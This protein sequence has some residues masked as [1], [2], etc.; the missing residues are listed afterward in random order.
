MLCTVS[1]HI[2]HSIILA[3]NV[4]VSHPDIAIC[5]LL[6]SHQAI[7]DIAYRKGSFTPD[8]RGNARRSTAAQHV[9]VWT[10]PAN[11]TCYYYWAT[12]PVWTNFKESSDRLP[13][14]SRLIVDRVI[15]TVKVAFWW[16]H[17]GVF[18]ASGRP[19]TSLNEVS[20]AFRSR[21]LIRRKFQVTISTLTDC[22]ALNVVTS[23]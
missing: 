9:K 13:V 23:L 19:N 12:N 5:K 18:L 15:E 20:Q 6:A 22:Q 3:S 11:L 14:G 4:S 16:T 10:L 21:L 7:D 17:T 2:V 1:L 8:A